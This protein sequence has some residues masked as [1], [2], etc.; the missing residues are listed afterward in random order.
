M[1]T[2]K[3]NCD[4]VW[5]LSINV[6][7]LKR[8]KSLLPGIDLLALEEGDPPLCVRLSTDVILLCDV[9]FVLLKPDADVLNV[10]DEEFARGLGGDGLAL[11]TAAL[12]AELQDFFLKLGRKDLARV[13]ATQETLVQK[14]WAQTDQAVADLDLDSLI[15]QSKTKRP[16]LK[17]SGPPFMDLPESSDLTQDLTHSGS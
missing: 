9:L 2:F 6:Q 3:D 10:T 12:G 11:A 17:A 14:I 5:T 8:V 4:R 15:A 1:K 7:A 13:I 16:S